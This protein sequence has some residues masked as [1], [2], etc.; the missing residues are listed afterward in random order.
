M[1][2]DAFEAGT[3][4]THRPSLRNQKSN[5]KQW[6]VSRILLLYIN[7][8]NSIIIVFKKKFWSFLILDYCLL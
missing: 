5:E 3:G 2:D 6:G 8:M 4:L 7:N 1:I